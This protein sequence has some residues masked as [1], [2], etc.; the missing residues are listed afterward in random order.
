MKL[1]DVETIVKEG[2]KMEITVS[3]RPGTWNVTTK[4]HGKMIERYRPLNKNKVIELVRAALAE[5]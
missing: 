1:K 2:H 5:S 4:L 3:S